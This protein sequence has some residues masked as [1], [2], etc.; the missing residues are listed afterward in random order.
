[1]DEVRVL[2]R[3]VEKV[4]DRIASDSSVVS[5]KWASAS[6]YAV[7]AGTGPSSNSVLHSFHVHANALGR[8]LRPN[9]R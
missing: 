7:A 1:M 3:M 2:A 6:V 5:A 4:S 9:L 8:T